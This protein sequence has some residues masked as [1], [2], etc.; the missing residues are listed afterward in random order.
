MDG[1]RPV[2][3]SFILIVALLV[4][5]TAVFA[6]L[7]LQSGADTALLGMKAASWLKGVLGIKMPAAQLHLLL[8][9]I[10]H[11]VFMAL[12]V[13]LVLLALRSRGKALWKSFAVSFA[14]GLVLSVLAEL[15]KTNI[16]GRHSDPSEMLLNAGGALLGA[17]LGTLI[18][19][20]IS[21]K[22][23]A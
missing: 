17:A 21:R 12:E 14:A 5:W 11:V 20:I 13:L 23:N 22:K 16:P 9:Q 7:T 10:A 1:N 19:F 4:L 18:S 2:G 15:V 6:V 3:R 8:R